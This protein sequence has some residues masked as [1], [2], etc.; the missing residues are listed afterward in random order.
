M[1]LI[2][3]VSGPLNM[4][5]DT[6]TAFL[7]YVSL[8][9]REVVRAIF[10]AVRDADWNTLPFTLENIQLDQGSNRFSLRFDARGVGVE[11]PLQWRGQVTG[12]PTGRIDYRF[13]ATVLQPFRRNRIGLCVLHPSHGCSGQFCQ[14]DHA[15]GEISIGEFP[16]WIAPHQ[17]YTDICAIEHDVDSF[18]VCRVEFSGETFEM[19]DHRNWTDASFKTYS[20][21]LAL[22]FPV[23][24]AAGTVIEQKVTVELK[25]GPASGAPKPVLLR[26]EAIP[27]QID[28]SQPLERPQ[29]GFACGE[30]AE[31]SPGVIDRLR[32]LRPDHIRVDV[33]LSQ[34]EWHNKLLAVAKGLSALSVQLELALFVDDPATAPWDKLQSVLSM[35]SL[36]I[37]RILL[38][39][40]HG[41]VTPPE[42]LTTA[43]RALQPLGTAISYV[44][45]TDAYF[46]EL[47]RGRPA[48]EAGCQ[49]CF[50][51][52]P[53]VHAF[54]NLSLAET[55]AAQPDTV[56]TAAQIFK[57]KVVVSPVTL[58]PRHNPNATST[59]DREQE[60][61]K[62]IDPRQ[63]GG[64]AAAWT[65]GVLASLGTQPQ[66]ESLTL[67]ET[68]GPRGVMDTAGEPFAMT[69]VLEAALRSTHFFAVQGPRPPQVVGCGL[70]QADQPPQLLLGNLSPRP[71]V[72]EI[73][74]QAKN[75]RLVEL[76]A[77]SIRLITWE[78]P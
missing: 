24:L 7:R 61:R 27:L 40:C 22:P 44:V 55:L 4:V 17:P 52:N 16:L 11:P 63:A 42:L 56:A 39:S 23:E 41:K 31:F 38:F 50:S 69:E 70:Q 14:I 8:D 30:A 28:W 75:K 25:G 45:G 71:R 76:D 3:L 18:V 33:D 62:A 46:A 49:V 67:F 5:F 60:L 36:K 74:D 48:A 66:L 34:P 9:D 43:Q 20:T 77:E 10:A 29:L 73:C 1:T 37:A 6:E 58:R 21:P 57:S 59:T 35:Q 13:H 68:H 15:D 54:D 2:P 65:V 72:A 19:E 12:S 64:F 47:N 53:Q 51:I 32:G 26:D 78:E